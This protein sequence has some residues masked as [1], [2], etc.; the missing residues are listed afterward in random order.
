MVT[1][2]DSRH[3]LKSIHVTLYHS[4]RNEAPRPSSMRLAITYSQLTR[5]SVNSLRMYSSLHSIFILLSSIAF[6]YINVKIIFLTVSII[7][8]LIIYST[9]FYLLSFTNILIYTMCVK[10]LLTIQLD[11]S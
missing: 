11:L 2:A 8:N 1:V 5:L 10:L 9:S 4:F 7:P 3:F 6:P